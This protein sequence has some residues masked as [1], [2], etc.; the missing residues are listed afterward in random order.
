[1]HIF[2]YFLVVG[3]ILF[4]VIF[5]A[6][7]MFGRPGKLPFTAEFAGLPKQYAPNDTIQ[8][9]PVRE[10]PTPDLN[11]SV[12][13][14]EANARADKVPVAP[15]KKVKPARDREPTISIAQTPERE[16]FW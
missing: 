10:L 16:R 2:S 8:I 9:L 5:F 14:P 15:Q 6:E 12:S 11:T 4:S 1:M 7:D 13:V 3:S